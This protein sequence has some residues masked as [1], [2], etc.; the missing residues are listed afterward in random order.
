M[1]FTL[2]F[3]FYFFEDYLIHSKVAYLKKIGFLLFIITF[4]DVV[5]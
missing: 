4:L 1:Y 2:S 3:L 5:D